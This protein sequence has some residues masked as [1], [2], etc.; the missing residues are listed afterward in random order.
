MLAPTIDELANEYQ[1]KIKVGKC[2]VDKAQQL[3]VQ[4]GV[5]NIP[6][7][8]LFKGGQPVQRVVGAKQ[9]REY[10]KLLDEA[11]AG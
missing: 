7:V 9:K 8:L 4:Y 2:D 3:A 11:V 6:T 10:K 5:Q 1:G